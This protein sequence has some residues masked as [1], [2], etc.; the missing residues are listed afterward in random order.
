VANAKLSG[1]LLAYRDVPPAPAPAPAQPLP[2]PS[3]VSAAQA[4][5]NRL[6]T[7]K[8]GLFPTDSTD[9][10]ISSQIEAAAERSGWSSPT[11]GDNRRFGPIVRFCLVIC[12]VV[13]STAVGIG[14]FVH[15]TGHSGPTIV[16]QSD[17]APTNASNPA[18]ANLSPPPSAE[19]QAAASGASAPV[20]FA[21]VESPITLAVSG[22]PTTPAAISDQPSTAAA[23]S[24]SLQP[25][26]AAA[27]PIPA[28]V[29]PAAGARLPPEEVAVLLVRGDALFG[30][31]DI[32]SARLC[33]ERAAEG[34]DAQAALRLGETYDPAFLARAH[35]NG[36]RGDATAA[37]RWYRNALALGAVEA[38]TLLKAVAANDGAAK[39]SKDMNQLFEQFLA[40]RDGQTH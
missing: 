14:L 21:L 39:R 32:V 20:T 30:S 31:G 11:T 17:P 16:L 3:V 12:G 38:E 28:P 1:S 10:P 40:R 6:E 34:G 4:S 29:S 24:I 5:A 25:E 15:A 36:A 13:A 23:T 37:A 22:A 33:Y 9:G 35:L 2:P 18:P 26:I 8:T 19:T 27:G 7:A